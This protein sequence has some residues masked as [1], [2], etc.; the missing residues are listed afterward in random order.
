[1]NKSIILL[2]LALSYLTIEAQNITAT[3]PANLQVYFSRPDGSQLIM[4]SENVAIL[5]DQL[6][7]RGEILVNE[8]KAEDELLLHLLDTAVYDRITISGLIPEGK[9]V[10]Q[11]VLNEKFTMEA[12]LSY[13]S[14]QSHILINFEL[15][16]RK[17]SLAN[18]FDI[19]GSGSV[20]LRDDFGIT[21]ET[22][23]DDKISFI[24]YQNVQT[25]T[26]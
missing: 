13:G 12:D 15:S 10:Y 5:Y 14:L 2:F 6:Q 7:M 16:N 23:F 22:G 17:T 4:T 20:S 26:Y 25:K 24:F 3:K 18:T 21:R 11:D 9:F 1:M 8:F 19:T